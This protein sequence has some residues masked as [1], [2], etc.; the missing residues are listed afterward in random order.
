VQW[1]IACRRILI[2]QI[3]DDQATWVDP[4]TDDLIAPIGELCQT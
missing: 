2:P 4:T 3:I 1:P